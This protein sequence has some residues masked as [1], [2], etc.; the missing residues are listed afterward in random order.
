MFY[1]RVVNNLGEDLG[2]VNVSEIL[3]IDDESKPITGFW[4]PLITVSFLP[5]N[6]NLLVSCYHRK[7]MIN[8]CFIYDYKSKQVLGDFSQFHFENCSLTNFPI[9]S[10]FS[11][12]ANVVYVF[13]R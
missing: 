11:L 8:Y 6:D 10:F 1:V 3:G 9:K 7:N 12:E 2:I 4:E 5:E 13:F